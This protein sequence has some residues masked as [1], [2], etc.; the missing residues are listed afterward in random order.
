MRGIWEEETSDTVRVEEEVGREWWNNG[1]IFPK[2]TEFFTQVLCSG[3]SRPQEVM[4]VHFTSV[5]PLR[6]WRVNP[7]KTGGGGKD[8]LGPERPLKSSRLLIVLKPVRA[9]NY[10]H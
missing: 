7:V 8:L 10:G 9:T 3:L 1:S 6:G 5:R 4:F 2:K